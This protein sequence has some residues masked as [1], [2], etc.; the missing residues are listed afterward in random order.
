MGHGRVCMLATLGYTVQSAGA[1]WEPFITRFPTSSEDPLLAATQVPFVGWFQILAFIGLSELWRYENVIAKYS[2]GVMPGD[3]G[4]NVKA[5][6]DGPRP[7]WFGP[8][9]TAGYSKEDFKLMQLREIKH[10]RLAMFGFFFFVIENAN[11]AKNVGLLP[12]FELPEYA[13]AVGDF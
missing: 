4:W 11:G 9:F 13:A 8:T 7:K 12:N 10:C 5:P 6:V 2:E 1:K 3:L